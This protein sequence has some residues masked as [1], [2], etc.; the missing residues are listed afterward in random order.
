MAE[1]RVFVCGDNT[2]TI[3]CPACNAAKTISAEPYRTKKNLIRVRCRCNEIF[4]LRLDFRDHYRK[5]TSLPGTYS[6]T[7]P[8]KVGG[9]VIHIR[10]ISREGIGFTVT[11][12]HHLEKGLELILKFRLDDK[13]KTK[14]EKKAIVRLVEKNYIGCQ[15]IKTAVEEKAL[16]FYLRP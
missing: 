10:N 7:T 6:I 2:A 16:G 4:S 15:F 3:I 8:E 9:G 5:E 13:Q 1:V 12:L 11:G 14:L